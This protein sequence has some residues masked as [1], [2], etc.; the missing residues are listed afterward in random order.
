M[1]ADPRLFTQPEE[2]ALY[3]VL[4]RIEREQLRCIAA[5]D[6]TGAMLCLLWLVQ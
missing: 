6:Y 2:W 4:C 5:G 1:I 3:A